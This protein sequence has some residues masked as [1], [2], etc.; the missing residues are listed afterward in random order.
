M[1]LIGERQHHEKVVP[2]VIRRVLQGEKV[3]IHADPAKTRSGTRFYIHSRNFASALVYLMNQ[4][5]SDAVEL[6][7]KIHVAG[8]REI[9]NLDLAQM[10]AG[11]I[12]KPLIY[13]LVDFH[14]SR[15]GHDL[16]YALDATKIR[17]MGWEQPLDIEQSLKKTVAW[18]LEHPRWLGL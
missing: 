14:S 12:G 8:E 18:Y 9:S 6:P 7:I 4:A 13:E 16:R 5:L 10:I 17:K 1:N 15:P 2:M 3:L 11:F